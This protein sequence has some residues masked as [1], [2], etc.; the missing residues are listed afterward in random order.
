MKFYFYFLKKLKKR[1]AGLA[2]S[3]PTAAWAY[4]YLKP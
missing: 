1:H 4:K 3:G 2:Y